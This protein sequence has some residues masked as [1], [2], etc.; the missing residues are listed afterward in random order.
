MHQVVGQFTGVGE[1]QQ[2]FGVQVEAADGLPFALVQARQAAEHG[3]AVLR[4]VMADDF[5]GRLVIGQ[6]A[7]FRRLDA[8]AD[9]LAVDLDLVAV[10]HALAHVGRLVVDRNLAFEDELFHFQA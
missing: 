8:K 1:Q 2:A 5:A 3:R 7:R 4:V 10:L 9:G 6:H